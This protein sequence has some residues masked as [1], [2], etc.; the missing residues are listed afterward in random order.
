M[1]IVSDISDLQEAR[2]EIENRHAELGASNERLGHIY[3]VLLGIRNVNQ[4]I[5]S[6]DDPRR[7][8][9]RACVNLTE[10]MGYHNAW[11][12]VLGGEAA[13]GLGLSEAG[14]VA[15]AASNG[16]DSGFETLREQLERGAFPDC[17]KRALETGDALVIGDPAVDCPDCPLHGEYGERAGLARRLE[18]DGVTY[19]ILTASVPAAY[20]RDAEEQDLFNEVAD[21]LA[22][23]LHK[24]SAAR[25]LRESRNDLKRAQALARVGSWRF[26]LNTGKV[27]ASEETRRIYGVEDGEITIQYVQTVPLPQY[28]EMLDSAL[29]A[30]VEEGA[31]YEVEFEIR[32][33]SD[34]AVRSIHSIAEYD[35]PQGIVVGT[36]Q[37]IT[38]RKEAEEALRDSEQRMSLVIKGSGLGT[39][40][41]NVQTN[42]TV[43]NE[44]WTAMLGYTLEE[45]TP[46]DYKTWERLVHP[47][48]LDRARQALTDCIEG[49]TPDYECEFRMK[50]KDGHWVWILDRG[51]IMTRDEAGK[52]LAMFGTHTDITEI[53]EAEAAQQASETRY[54]RLFECA[55]DGI[56]ILD[57]ETGKVV[58][59]NPYLLHLLGHDRDALV[60]KPLWEIGPF[61]DIAASRDLF[62]VLQEKEYVRYEHLPLQSAS[63]GLVDVEFVSNVY[64]ANDLKVIQ[65]N[66]RDITERKRAEEA[67]NREHAMLARTEAAAHVGSWEWEAEGDKVTWSEELF[68]IFGLKPAEEAP[69]F[70]EHQAFYVPEDRARLARAVEECMTN[71]TPYDLEVRVLR[72][73]GELRHCLVRG[74]PER[75]TDGVV[76]RLY[77]SLQDITEI[78]RAEE[79]ITTLSHMLDD[80]PASITI[81]DTDGRFLFANAATASLHGYESMEQFME[82]D[83]HDLDVPESEALLAERFR[84][85]AEEGEARFEVEHYRKDGSTFPLEIL[86]KQIE[87]EGRPAILSIATDITERKQAEETLRHSHELMQ[88]IIEHVNSAVAVHDRDL[89][90]VYVSQRYLQDYGIQ[91]QDIIG[92]HHYDVFPDLPEKWREVHRKALAGEVSRAEKDPYERADGTLEWTRWECRPWYEQD[93]TIGGIIVYTEVITERVKAEEALVEQQALLTAI[94][95]NAPLVLM[96]V[97]G[98][99]RIRQVNGFASQFA[100]RPVEEML[101]LRGGE[102]HLCG[103]NVLLAGSLFKPFQYGLRFLFLSLRPLDFSGNLRFP[104]CDGPFGTQR[105]G[106]G[107]GNLGLGQGNIRGNPG[108][109]HVHPRPG[110]V[111]KLAA[112]RFDNP[113]KQQRDRHPDGQRNQRLGGAVRKHPVVDHHGK[114]TGTDRQNIG[115]QRGH[116]HLSVRP[117]IRRNR[118]PEPTPATIQSLDIRV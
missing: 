20:A 106:L 55:Q 68:R 81:H 118:A 18:C 39:W 63:G 25:W 113:V 110:P 44:Q 51:R 5:V 10:T 31:P 17:M 59:V 34:D 47:E 27:I 29:K 102:A 22:F 43:L 36:I 52:P 98:E 90:Y 77:G 94:Y 112:Q 62:R 65:C 97:D 103:F 83:L 95:C 70:A 45:L 105:A 69:S 50:H 26:D 60:G 75:D 91:E 116:Q 13:R 16:F 79:R 58:D 9:E 67:L 33:P 66:I 117:F 6:E 15:A 93:G 114:N 24:I 40:E 78:R 2:V 32:R 72:C 8:V 85:I 42:E 53:K 54:R 38:E 3:R 28:R 56:L 21:D 41:W 23:A 101:G 104:Q 96:V 19:G 73:D 12:A 109:H 107:D 57:A 86:A 80:A 74:F 4:L 82:V 64:L 14:P 49:K 1:V 11:I 7:L 89:R 84:K 37:D 115:N 100:G 71:G 48:D 99:R 76:K 88:Y 61:H 111:D 30:L 87:W 92:R 46:Y 108:G 35:A